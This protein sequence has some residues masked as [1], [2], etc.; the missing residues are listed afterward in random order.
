MLANFST[1]ELR[2]KWRHLSHR[3]QLMVALVIGAAI[4]FLVDALVFTPQARREQAMQDSQKR[5]Q[6]QLVVLAA[7]MAAV[8]KTRV[9]SLAQAQAEHALIKKQ[10]TE[11]E[12]LVQSVAVDAPKVKSLMAGLLGSKSSRVKVVAIKTLPVKPL[13][14][15]AKAPAAGAAPAS[16]TPPL[17]AGSVYKHGLEIE[18]RGTYLDLVAFLASMEDANP[19]LLWSNA[20]LTAGTYPENTLRVSVFLLSTQANL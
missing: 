11:L 2:D 17:S 6:S 9:D 10:A 4:Y 18:L 3:E 19:R 14:A 5:L 13:A 7:D 15:A 12:G 16:G 8:D 20:T 1:S